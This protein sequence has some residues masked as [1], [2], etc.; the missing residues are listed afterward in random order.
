MSSAY[1]TG[2]STEKTP[3]NVHQ[4]ITEALDIKCMATLVLLHLSTAF[5]IIDQGILQKRL[6]CPF[7]LTRF[8]PISVT[9]LG[10]LP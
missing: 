7:M 10:V 8:S 1:R 5:D 3:L 2:H 4:D 6:E 9:G